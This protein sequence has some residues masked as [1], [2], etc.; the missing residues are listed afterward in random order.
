MRVCCLWSAVFRLLAEEEEKVKSLLALQEEQEEQILQ[1]EREKQ[2]LK[3]E[4]E[5]KCQA[6]EDA[7]GQLEKVRASRRRVDQDIAVRLTLIHSTSADLHCTKYLSHLEFVV[8][9]SSR[10]VFHTREKY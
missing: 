10:S 5:R 4:M 8:Q 6:L 2:E 1:T 3:L 7:Q 9:I